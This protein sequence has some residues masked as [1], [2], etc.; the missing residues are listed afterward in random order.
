MT[1]S[2]FFDRLEDA[3]FP[4]QRRDRLPA[5]WIA[6]RRQAEDR[7]IQG[8]DR[9]GD[10]YLTRDNAGEGLEEAAD[11]ANYGYFDVLRTDAEGGDVDEALQLALIAAHHFYEGHRTLHALRAK[12]PPLPISEPEAEIST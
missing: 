11:G 8:R 3:L 5:D 7:E 4:N 6:F 1:L 12:T 2:D 9:F 10:E